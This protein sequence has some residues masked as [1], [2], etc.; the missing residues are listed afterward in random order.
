M[1]IDSINIIKKYLETEQ[2]RITEKMLDQQEQ[3]L[4]HKPIY[5]EFNE[6]RRHN[7]HYA[8][9]VLS[10]QINVLLRNDATV[11]ERTE[12]MR[13]ICLYSMMELTATRIDAATAKAD[14][15]LDKALA[16]MG[17]AIIDGDSAKA[18]EAKLAVLAYQKTLNAFKAAGGAAV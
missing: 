18:E 1:K 2:T 15:G 5:D 6:Y 13:I 10:D 16:Q 12:I 7:A 3:G 8:D 9:Q 14:A 11:A 4:T 17:K